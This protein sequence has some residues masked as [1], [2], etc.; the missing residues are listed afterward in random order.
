MKK[1]CSFVVGLLLAGQLNLGLAASCNAVEA[2]KDLP[3]DVKKRL[4]KGCRQSE[5]SSSC[6]SQAREKKLAGQKREKFIRECFSRTR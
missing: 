3:A 6:E 5:A 1:W 4:L 2:R